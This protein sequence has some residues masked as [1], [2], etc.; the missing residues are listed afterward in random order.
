MAAEAV[1]ELDFYTSYTGRPYPGE[2]GMRH[3]ARRRGTKF[4]ANLMLNNCALLR[5]ALGPKYGWEPEAMTVRNLA[6]EVPGPPDELRAHRLHRTRLILRDLRD[7]KP[8]V[9]H[10]IIQPQL[11]IRTGSGPHDFAYIAPDLMVLDRRTG[12]YV[13]GEEKSFIVRD[14]VADPGDLNLTRRQ[15]AAEILA[16]RSEAVQVGLELPISNRRRI[17]LR[18]TLW[19]HPSR[20]CRRVARCRR[21]RG[22]AGHNCVVGRASPPHNSAGSDT[23]RTTCLSR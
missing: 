12:M 2:Y 22:P 14:N 15:A 19:A 23:K 18:Y 8:D 1:P 7:E 3:S 5:R 21:V 17:H 6:E 9:P 16:L 10:L 13:P 11:R 20:T 4:E